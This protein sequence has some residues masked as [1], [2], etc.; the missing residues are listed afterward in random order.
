MTLHRKK[1]FAVGIGGSGMSGLAILLKKMGY[2]VSGSDTQMSPQKRKKLEKHKIEVIT[3]HDRKNISKKY[4]E[5]IYSQAIPN[6]NP[7]LK[8]AKKKKIACISYPQALGK[9][10]SGKT[11]ICVAGTHGKTTTTAMIASI[12]VSAGKE[13]T[14][15][16]GSE[17]KELGNENE[18][19][20]KSDIAVIETCEYRKSFHQ[21]PPDILVITNIDFD[22]IDFYKTKKNYDKAFLDYMNMV[23][24]NGTIIYLEGDKSVEKLKKK[25]HRPHIIRVSNTEIPLRIPG[26]HN[27]KN[28]ALALAVA[29]LLKIPEKKSLGILKKFSG[30]SRRLEYKGTYQGT[31]IY[32]DYGHHPTE[33]MATL[34]ALREIYPRE[35][36]LT[37][38][39][40]HQ[41]SRTK[42]FLKD[43]AR[44][45][46]LSDS[47]IIPNIY[48]ARDTAKDKSSMTLAK[49]VKEIA[50]HH[51]D[52]SEGRSMAAT[53]KQLKK[54]ARNFDVVIT[55]GAG[56]VY[57]VAN[58]LVKH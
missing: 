24:K 55:M 20:G 31:K 13:P 16:V 54:T 53:M 49:L 39:Q 23:S 37:V 28:A 27:Q 11:K 2:D 10:L 26:K 45:F 29:S 46:S 32:D 34:S 47:L 12:L 18:R 1:I 33:V 8:E 22:H 42:A 48:A 52:V 14:V 6:N 30:T 44:A 40:P 5:I 25:L 7:E 43:F 41:H 4:G 50:K 38:F 17:V 58:S 21:I 51:P 15:I 3:R 35:K 56:D 9:Y 36:I 19:L 57:K